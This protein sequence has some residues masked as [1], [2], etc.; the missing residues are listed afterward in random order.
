LKN[1][2]KKD[3]E[4]AREELS[5]WKI[6]YKDFDPHH[7]KLRESLC[8]LAN[9][10]MGIRSALPGSVS[11]PVHYPATYIAGVYNTLSTKVSGKKVFNEDLVK[12]PDPMFLTFRIDEE[13]WFDLENMDILRYR[14]E[15]DMKSG[16]L[17]RSTRLRDNQGRVTLI[18][19][20]RFV[21][22]ADPHIA[23]MRYRI[24]PENYCGDITIGSCLD[25]DIKNA[26]VA[27]YSGLNSR[28]LAVVSSGRVKPDIVHL[29]V[30]TV[31][32]GIKISMASKLDIHLPAGA[33]VLTSRVLN[34]HSK[35][36]REI[37]ISTVKKKAVTVEKTSAVFT[38]KSE[39]RAKL[40]KKAARYV[41][42]A[43]SFEIML[44]EHRSEWRK[45]W[46]ACDINIQGDNFSQTILRFNIFHLLQSASKHNAE[47]DAGLG[48]R[49]LHGESYRG[50]IF[51]DEIFFM[52]FFSSHM[53]KTA[54][55]LLMYR[56]RR[57]DAARKYAAANGY[58]GAMFPWQ[59]G[60]SGKEETQSLHLN[61]ISGKWGPDLSRNQ[62]HVSFAVAYNVWRHW[63]IS[64]NLKFMRE[65]G[66]EMI[67]SIA[68]FASSLCRY[69]RSTG[70]YHTKGLMGPDEFHEK[71]PGSDTPGLKDNAYSN[72]FIVW[73]LLKAME[74]LEILPKAF[75]L[76]LRKDLEIT[77][78]EILRWK[79]IS[80][81]MN[82]LISENGIISQF[83]GY[84]GL[85]EL[86]WD[87]Y[88][89]KYG[90]INRMDRIL[91]A[92]GKSPDQY[93]VIKQADVLMIF[94]LFPFDEIQQ[95]FSGLGY[96]CDKALLRKN[97]RYYESHTSHG[98]TL[99]KV[100]HCYVAHLLGLR[101]LSKNWFSNVLEADVHDFK[102]GTTLEGI[103]TG[104]MG[105]SIDIVMRA[106]SGL[107]I[108]L[109]GIHLSPLMPDGWKSM[110]FPFRAKNT[111]FLVSVSKNSARVKKLKKS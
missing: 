24:T 93:K 86:D 101:K 90:H 55:A 80:R 96:K 77:D 56:Y 111:W 9:G 23:A 8:T 70:K 69:D 98:S 97:Y 108:G 60:S 104:I 5:G 75:R 91:K 44:R 6:T 81:K 22:M 103:H 89:K 7:E 48:P 37:C 88:R 35:I 62:R 84:F 43:P 99:S 45:L 47:I 2:S 106:F 53:P 14:Q 20:E 12:C 73:T 11:S 79:D 15:L 63:T 39:T 107:R 4:G 13:E 72:F 74:V 30:R 59:S 109:K 40:W 16:V 105:G 34:D 100:V 18:E 67:L 33:K 95:I 65:Y 110:R 94:F 17:T 25:G 29:T 38:E 54:E 46:K 64:G 57:L 41:S 85:K 76:K 71:L 1:T 31:Q 32:S 87:S 92:E 36:T 21:H 83:D 19:E 66:A 52:P 3:Y 68:I 26:G 42:G 78:D 49:G 10:Y 102:S 82:I 50:H 51:W 28:H 27:R 58:S 61:P